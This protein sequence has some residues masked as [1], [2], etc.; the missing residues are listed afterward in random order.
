S[1]GAATCW[2]L[3][4]LRLRR[5]HDRFAGSTG[6]THNHL[7]GNAQVEAD[8]PAPD[9][10]RRFVE[11]GEFHQ[12]RTR[13]LFALGKREN[14]ACLEIEVPTPPADPRRGSELW[15][16]RRNRRH[17][18]FELLLLAVCP[19]TDEQRQIGHL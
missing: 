12:R 8:D 18:L 19:G 10:P 15:L 14:L 6:E 5:G 17:E 7:P 13:G 1:A 9:Q 11:P 16:E 2:C 3:P 4:L